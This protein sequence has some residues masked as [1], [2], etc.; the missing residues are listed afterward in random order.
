LQVS[1]H[2]PRRRA[3]SSQDGLDVL[4]SEFAHA[5]FL[6]AYEL[7]VAH[8]ARTGVLVKVAISS[9]SCET[10]VGLCSMTWTK[11]QC[12]AWNLTFSIACVKK[13][14]VMD[15]QNGFWR[16]LGPMSSCSE[17]AFGWESRPTRFFLFLFEL[18]F[19]SEA[20]GLSEEGHDCL[21]GGGPPLFCGSE[22]DGDQVIAECGPYLRVP[23]GT[24]QAVM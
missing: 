21:R 3:W 22:M 18:G 19:K 2:R 17:R 13:S 23:L 7:R 6:D 11:P 15:S 24:V 5:A 20:V 12:E 10:T 8:R 9:G 1:Q 14:G 4:A 16:L